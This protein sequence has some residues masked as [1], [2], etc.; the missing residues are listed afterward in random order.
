[1]CNVIPLALARDPTSR[2]VLKMFL[3]FVIAD[4]QI[5]KFDQ[6]D[7]TTRN[8]LKAYFMIQDE[9]HDRSENMWQE[10]E[11]AEE[12]MRSS[13][14]DKERKKAKHALEKASKA[15]EHASYYKDQVDNAYNKFC[16]FNNLPDSFKIK[17]WNGK[18]AA[19]RDTCTTTL[20]PYLL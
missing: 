6:L 12:S 20:N 4:H 16:Q 19:N 3:K 7:E 14:N 11:D 10:R 15:Y 18:F 8:L 1:M 13:R 2:R 17:K 5:D 9:A